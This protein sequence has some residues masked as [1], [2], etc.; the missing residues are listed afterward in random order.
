MP[1]NFLL[2]MSYVP[3]QLWNE[4]VKTLVLSCGEKKYYHHQN[5]KCFFQEE[6][7][8]RISKTNQNFSWNLIF[9]NYSIL[10]EGKQI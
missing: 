4:S 6:M 5:D 9:Q 7:G 2:Q 10:T 1:T 3:S 8:D